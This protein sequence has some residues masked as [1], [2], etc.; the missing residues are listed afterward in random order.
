MLFVASDQYNICVQHHISFRH[1]EVN[2][3][4]I[5]FCLKY[6]ILQSVSLQNRHTKNYFVKISEKLMFSG[7]KNVFFY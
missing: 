4:Y 2:Y 7:K 6:A 1:N 3:F 5:C